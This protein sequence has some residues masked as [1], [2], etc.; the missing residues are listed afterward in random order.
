LQQLGADAL[1]LPQ[2]ARR[3]LPEPGLVSAQKQR[4]D[5]QELFIDE[6]SK[7]QPLGVVSQLS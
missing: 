4:Y 2:G 5:A 3:E 7:V 6:G 1:A